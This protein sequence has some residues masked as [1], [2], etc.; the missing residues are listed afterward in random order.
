MLHPC[1]GYAIRKISIIRV[2]GGRICLISLFLTSTSVVNERAF[3]TV[4]LT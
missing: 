1:N 4:A 3:D 2:N